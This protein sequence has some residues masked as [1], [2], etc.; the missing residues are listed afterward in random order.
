MIKFNLWIIQK[1]GIGFSKIVAEAIQDY[2]NN[3]FE[4]SV[5]YFNKI[6][7]GLLI[8]DRV[9]CLI[10]GDIIDKNELPSPELYRWLMNFAEECKKTE[11]VLK[12]ISSYYI[13]LTNSELSSL[14][15]KLFR[16]FNFY[17]DIFPSILQ[18]KLEGAVLALEENTLQSV[19]DYSYEFIEFFKNNEKGGNYIW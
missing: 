1:E 17:I 8:E 12:S 5:G 6:E 14:W 10:L 11:F 16:K 13:S 4:V 2:L 18:L 3:Y 15:I 19:K 7:P 9:D